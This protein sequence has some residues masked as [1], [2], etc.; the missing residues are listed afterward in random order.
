M[1]GNREF[2]KTKSVAMRKNYIQLLCCFIVVNCFYVKCISQS[3]KVDSVATLF[4]SVNGFTSGIEGPAVDQ[5]GV[6]YAVNYSEQGTIGMA[7]DNGQCTIFVRLPSQS[8]GNGIRFDRKGNMFIADYTQHSIL[9]IEKGSKKVDV[10]AHHVTWNQPN[11]IAIDSKGRIFASDPNWNEGTG[12]LWSVTSGGKVEL[13]ES[14]MGTTN[15][16]EI[17]PAEDKLYVNESRQLK[18][19]VYDLDRRGRISNKKSFYQFEDFGLDG[20]RC[21]QAGNLFVTRYGKGAVL[22]LSPQGEVL[23]EVRLNG[24]RPSNLAFGGPDGKTVYVTLA[25]KG[26]IDSFR[27]SIPGRSFMMW[28]DN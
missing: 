16:I 17:N 24:E 18:I 3:L 10:F 26:C 5:D 23:A 21:D 12:Q 6:L 1:A 13:L 4:T 2:F 8:I 14:D 11:D 9:I 19:W 28:K 27:T 15:G 20:M 22:V 25:D 7:D